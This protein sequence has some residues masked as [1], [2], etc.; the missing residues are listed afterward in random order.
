MIAQTHFL[1]IQFFD[2]KA[3][4]NIVNAIMFQFPV[5]GGIEKLIALQ[6]V[7]YKRIGND[8]LVACM[9][10]PEHHN[11]IPMVMAS[12][13]GLHEI[14][15]KRPSELSVVHIDSL[16]RFHTIQSGHVPIPV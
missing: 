6:P 10:E 2:F 14:D 13:E 16:A 12:V 4:G 7:V 11:A 5:L 8:E 9:I 15:L 3:G 1:A